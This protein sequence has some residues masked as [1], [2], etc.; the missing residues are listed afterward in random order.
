MKT[1]V[2]VVKME[3]GGYNM[4]KIFSVIC[5]MAFIFLCGTVGNFEMAEELAKKA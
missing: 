3:I 4:K 1:A 5:F 2:M